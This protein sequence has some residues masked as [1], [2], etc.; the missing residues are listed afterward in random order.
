MSFVALS[1]SL[2]VQIAPRFLCF[3]MLKLRNRIDGDDGDLLVMQ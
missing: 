2:S 3:Y 1:F